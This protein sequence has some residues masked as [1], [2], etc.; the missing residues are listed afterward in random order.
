ML[1]ALE[2]DPGMNSSLAEIC[3]VLRVGFE[4]K[5]AQV[6]GSVCFVLW[7]PAVVCRL[8]APSNGGRITF[9]TIIGQFSRVSG[10]HKREAVCEDTAF[11]SPRLRVPIAPLVSPISCMFVCGHVSSCIV[12]LYSFCFVLVMHSE[13]SKVTLVP[14]NSTGFP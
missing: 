4:D 11:R 8:L 6:T 1:P 9:I 2:E 12:K 3:Q 10:I 14:L 5:I 13:T 7:P